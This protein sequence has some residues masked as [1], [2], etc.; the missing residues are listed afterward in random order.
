MTSGSLTTPTTSMR[1]EHFKLRASILPVPPP[2]T[3]TRPTAP[4]RPSRLLHA[5]LLM[6]VFAR[7]LYACPCGGRLTPVAVIRDPDIVQAILAALTEAKQPP[8]RGPPRRPRCQ[9]L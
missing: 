8:A 5:Q 6:R 7:D 9:S 3:A 4:A 2:P 1:P